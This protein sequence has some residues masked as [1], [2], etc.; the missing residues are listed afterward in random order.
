MQLS[1]LLRVVCL[2]LC[3]SG[4]LQVAFEY[5]A[6]FP[7]SALLHNAGNG[8]ARK[9]EQALFRLTLAGRLGPWLLALLFLLPAYVRGED[10]VAAEHVG[11]ASLTL[12]IGL[13]SWWTFV[14]M[15]LILTVYRLHRSCQSYPEVGRM[16]GN[17]PVLLYPGPRSV[18]AVAGLFS[19]R[20][21]VSQSLLETHRFS[22]AALQVAFAHEGAHV[23]HRDNLK[24]LLLGLV[25]H[26][27]FFT[28]GQPSPVQFWRLAAEMA[29]D[30]EG[31]QGQPELSLLLAEM[32]V[33]LAQ[34]DHRL[35]LGMMALCSESEHL[36]FRVE[37]LL[38]P[39]D[40]SN[41]SAAAKISRQGKLSLVITMT[42]F[43]A[44]LIAL[45]YGCTVLGHRAAELLFRVG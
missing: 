32:L 44:F 14:F 22:A 34:E 28:K 4:G 12:A 8:S 31:T 10:N 2:V 21:I 43:A 16:P 19:A 45:C 9:A 23:R 3:G 7:A 38:Q 30:E 29:A 13:L 27:P 39:I 17:L 40:R 35:S 18:M 33:T 6:W 24:A 26:L 37:R 41:V 11:V 42:A 25:P 36:R 5:A 1:Y 20:I 15:R